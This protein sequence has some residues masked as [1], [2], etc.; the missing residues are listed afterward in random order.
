MITHDRLFKELLTT[1]FREFIELFAPRLAERV[2]WESLRFLDKEIWTDVTEGQRHEADLIAQ[3]RLRGEPDEQEA[4]F[5]IHVE[6]QASKQAEFAER[7][8]GY[9]ARLRAKHRLPIYP[10]V[11][12]SYDKP[13]TIEPDFFRVEIA[14]LKVVEFRFRVIQLNRLSWRNYVKQQNPVASALMAKMQIAP[15]DRAKVKW[16]CLRLMLTLKLDPAKMQLISGFVDTYLKLSGDELEEFEKTIRKEPLARREKVMQLM[17][18]WME[19]GLRQGLRQGLQQ[20]LQQGQSSLVLRQLP[21]RVGPLTKRLEKQ[22]S[23][24]SPEQLELLGDALLDFNTRADL[25]KWL[26]ENRATKKP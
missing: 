14:D 1:F 26:Q 23:A 5:L 3:V 7:M 13:R 9:F 20:G 22:V 12:F 11:L 15:E 6:N 10:I 25:E 2:A 19:E 21:R 18:N 24:L 4:F 8:F 16:E 17:G